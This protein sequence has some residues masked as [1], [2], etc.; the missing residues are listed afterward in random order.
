ML[1][2]NILHVRETH[3]II[4]GKNFGDRRRTNL[5]KETISSKAIS[6]QSIIK[7][8]L[9]AKRE[10]HQ[11]ICKR[12]DKWYSCRESSKK[13]VREK[14]GYIC[15]CSWFMI[16]TSLIRSDSLTFCHL[17]PDMQRNWERDRETKQHKILFK[18]IMLCTSKC[19]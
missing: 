4:R 6:N 7:S 18:I 3:I 12:K 17:L 19:A 5:C 13:E 2:W 8:L 11:Y 9:L 14:E 10:G 16:E 15:T 1:E